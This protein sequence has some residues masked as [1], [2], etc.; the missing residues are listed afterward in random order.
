[1]LSVETTAEAQDGRFS[2]TDSL[3]DMG[4]KR[5]QNP[6]LGPCMIHNLIFRAYL[7]YVFQ[8]NAGKTTLLYRL[9]VL[10]FPLWSSEGESS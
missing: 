4:E 10:C 3:T 8:D 5:D 9:K 2:L 6:D 1:M 7:A